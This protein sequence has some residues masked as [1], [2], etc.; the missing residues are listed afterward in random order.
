MHCNLYCNSILTVQ[1]VRVYLYDKSDILFSVLT[2]GIETEITA[3]RL[4][5]PSLR[6]PNFSQILV[7]AFVEC[8]FK[9]SFTE[10]S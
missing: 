2:Y 7:P 3:I 8:Y 6:F 5:I 1:Q 10:T 4:S 9:G